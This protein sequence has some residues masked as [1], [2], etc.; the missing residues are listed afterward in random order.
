M[1]SFTFLWIQKK[2]KKNSKM[3]TQNFK[4]KS[5]L[6]DNLRTEDMKKLK[7]KSQ[8]PKKVR[9][10]RHKF[11]IVRYKLAILRKKSELCFF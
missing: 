2:K 11:R 3:Q 9:I 4:K 8:L 6:W 7:K 5:E 10:V 1:G